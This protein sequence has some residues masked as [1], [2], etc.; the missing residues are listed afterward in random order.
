MANRDRFFNPKRFAKSKTAK[1]FVDDVSNQLIGL[2]KHDGLRQRARKVRDKEI[3]LRQ[4][5]AIACEAAHR[6]ITDPTK[7]IA[8]SLSNQKLS[9]KD[10]ESNILNNTLSQ[11]LKNLARP[12]MAFIELEAGNQRLGLVTTF[13]AGKRLITRINSLK[14]TYNDFA[15]E[16]STNVIEL[17]ETK[18]SST[19][20]GKLIKY[21]ETNLTRQYRDEIEQINAHLREA[22]I[23]YQGDKDIDDTR[24]DLKR[25][26]NNGSFEDSGRLYGGF[27]SN[28]SNDDRKDITI[29]DE[30]LVSIDFGQMG[31]RLAYSLAKAPITFDDGYLIPGWEKAREGTKKLINVMLNTNDRNEWYVSSTIKK[32]YKHIEDIERKLFTDIFSHHSAIAHLFKQPLG[33]KFMFLESEILIDILLELNRKGITA[34]PVHDCVLVKTSA[35][36]ITKD[37]MLRVFN[38]HTG[39]VGSVDV[40]HL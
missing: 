27:W 38:E 9:R 23:C 6:Y 21:E 20:K 34:L 37:I 17:R 2:E 16:K 19:K 8:I 3:F 12:E 26:F 24:R 15:V 25:I 1:D 18:P 10:S 33:T 39:V 5:E 11:N 29:D 36:D 7:R 14:L 4:I 32:Q 40:E 22:D 30:W 28:M 13:W 31:L 35:A